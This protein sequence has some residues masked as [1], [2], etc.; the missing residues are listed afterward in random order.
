MRG[1][2]TG[3]ISFGLVNVGVK[4]LT[5]VRDHEVRFNQIE[6]DTG[7]RIGYQKV[8]KETGQPV[9]AGDI[10]MGYELSKNQ[11]VTFEKSEIDELKPESSRVIEI[12]DFVELADID[13]IYFNNTYWLAPTDEAATRSYSLL[14]EAMKQSGRA[15]IGSVVMR[16]KEYL[17]AIRVTENALAMS[18]MRFAD[19]VV[20]AADIPDIPSSLTEP[21]KKELAL[22]SQI[23]EALAEDWDPEQYHDTYTQE[24]RDLIER[25]SEGELVTASEESPAQSAKIVDLMEALQASVKAVKDDRGSGDHDAEDDAADDS[26]DD[27]ADDSADEVDEKPARK[28]AARKSPAKKSPAKKASAKKAPAAKRSTAESK[29]PARKSA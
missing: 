7:S 20:H 6:R 22:A 27:A 23:V 1:I 25:K 3:S 11:Y 29:E 18:T 14:V 12:S 21:G 24:L 28:A 2:W 17:A 9:E 10:V 5:A 15:A 16:N 13:P 8:S 26:A 19:E 4:A